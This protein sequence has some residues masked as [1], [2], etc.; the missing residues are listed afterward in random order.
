MV[1]YMKDDKHE[2][3]TGKDA[4]NK[5]VQFLIG[6]NLPVKNVCLFDC[7]TSRSETVRNNVYTCVLPKY[8]NAKRMQKGIENAL[9]LDSIDVTPFYSSKVKEG[10]Y[11]D[12]NTIVEFQKMEFCDYICSLDS[13]TLK[14]V[15]SNL[16]TTIDRLVVLF[17]E[18]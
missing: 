13:L 11:G 12:D 2:E 18:A 3:N 6:R 9:E 17:R 4:L 8:E 5:A 10:D 1:G 15:F 14:A 7:D 16:K